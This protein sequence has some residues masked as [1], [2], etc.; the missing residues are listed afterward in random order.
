MILETLFNILF[1]TIGS[2][3]NAL[4]ISDINISTST[5]GAFFDFI[6]VAFYL[7]PMGTVVKIFGISFIL[8]QLRIAIAILKTLW[9]ILPLT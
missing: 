7:L 1:N 5:M 3:L 2:I 8:I 9:N 6:S 4:P